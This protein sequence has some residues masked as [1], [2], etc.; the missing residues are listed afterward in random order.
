M[1]ENIWFRCKGCGQ[2]AAF[3]G[4]GL[5]PWYPAGSVGHSK[6]PDQIRYRGN[7]EA[8]RV[9]CA[10]YQ[11]LSAE[12]F[13]ELHHDAERIESPLDFRPVLP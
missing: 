1:N 10:I 12:A 7:A 3:F 6:P 13:W 11:R 4:R 8:S 2:P 9:K 5:P